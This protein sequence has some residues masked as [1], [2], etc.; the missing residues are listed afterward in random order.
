MLQ[1]DAGTYTIKDSKSLAEKELH[2]IQLG[3]M[4][5]YRARRMTAKHVLER[6]S[7]HFSDGELKKALKELHEI[8]PTAAE[9]FLREQ[10]QPLQIPQNDSSSDEGDALDISSSGNQFLNAL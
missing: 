7:T 1:I 5:A 6:A 10:V 3:T 2:E 8:V 4:E 9:R